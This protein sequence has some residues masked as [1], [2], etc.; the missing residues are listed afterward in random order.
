MR[1]GS[2]DR[3]TEKNKTD[4]RS[5]LLENAL[6]FWKACPDPEHR[7]EMLKSFR[8]ALAEDQYLYALCLEPDC[9]QQSAAVWNTA[10]HPQRPAFRERI[11]YPAAFHEGGVA[12]IA[13]L[14][15]KQ[16]DRY[17]GARP[18]AQGVW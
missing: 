2:P 4:R 5:G 12:Y 13:F 16:A 10:I 8:L 3:I 9:G 15:R 18:G 7:L 1:K 6:R 14:N 11:L 17:A